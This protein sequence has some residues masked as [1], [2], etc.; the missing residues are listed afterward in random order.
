MSLLP[1]QRSFLKG[2][3]HALT[4]T[5]RIGRNRVTPRVVAETNRT[6]DAH[7]LIKVKV[8][9]DEG[10]ERRSVSALLAHRTGAELVGIVGKIAIL[11]RQR[12][13]KPAIRLP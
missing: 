5:V 11:F 3:A 2:L 10:D 1:R 13:E 4:P 6:L 8:D 9:L 7:E 12:D